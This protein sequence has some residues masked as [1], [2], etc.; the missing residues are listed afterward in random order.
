M[1]WAHPLLTLS[2]MPE[3]F[4]PPHPD[5]VERG[6]SPTRDDGAEANRQERCG[7]TDRPVLGELGGEFTPA[8]FGVLECSVEPER[9]RCTVRPETGSTP[10]AM[11][12]SKT[13]GLRS[14]SDP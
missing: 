3:T 14:R 12:I 1:S 11:R 7:A 5:G 2:G 6:T 8:L 9:A 10:T 4:D 13:P